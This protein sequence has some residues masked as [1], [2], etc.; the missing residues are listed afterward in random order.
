MS[1]ISFLFCCHLPKP[2]AF[3]TC[4]GARTDCGYVVGSVRRALTRPQNRPW[5]PA[6]ET[7]THKFQLCPH[8]LVPQ[9]FLPSPAPAQ[10]PLKRVK[11]LELLLVLSE[12]YNIEIKNENLPYSGQEHFAE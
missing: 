7:A 6:K 4:S 12:V 8:T 1:F 10:P 11:I 5:A 2:Q 3:L 9:H